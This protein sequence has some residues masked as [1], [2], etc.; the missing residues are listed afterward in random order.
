MKFDVSPLELVTIQETAAFDKFSRVDW[1][2]LIMSL[3]LLL[4]ILW[5]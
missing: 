2:L 4:R 1:L 3:G 5:N